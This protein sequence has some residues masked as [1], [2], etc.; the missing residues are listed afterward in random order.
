MCKFSIIIAIYNNGEYLK[1]RCLSSLKK[2]SMF[3]DIEL[4]LIDDGSTDINTINI[5]KELES[6]YKNIKTFFF[7]DGGSGSASRPR[8]CGIKLSTTDYITYLDP[9]NEAYDDNY[10]KLYDE[11]SSNSLDMVVGN[12]LFRDDES[13]VLN[14]YY[15]KFLS[16]NKNQSICF[17]GKQTLYSM[18]FMV[19][20][21]QATMVKKSVILENNLNMVCQGAGEDTLFF[22]ELIINSKSTKVINDIIHIYHLYTKGSVTNT[23]NKYYFKKHLLVEKSKRKFLN[24]TQ[25]L[26]AYLDIMHENY[27]IIWIF[28][29]LKK[30]DR[31]ENIEDCKKYIDEIYYIYKDVWEIKNPTLIEYVKD[32]NL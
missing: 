23:I 31:N 25:L 26:D 18:E 6:E 10:K 3:E 15:S 32:R 28:D 30:V 7:N 17:N 20:S 8:N 22:Y 5:I 9:D 27:F 19:Q 24:D 21:I 29:K 2:S 16:V 1:N 12:I 11:I 4:I 13:D 14:D